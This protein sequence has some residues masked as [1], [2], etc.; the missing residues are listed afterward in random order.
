M[1]VTHTMLSVVEANGLLKMD[2]SAS[3]GPLFKNDGKLEEEQGAVIDIK[4]IDL[5]DSQTLALLP[6]V[7][8][9][10]FFLV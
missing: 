2:S 9:R 8:L 7:R 5:E 10:G 4:S 1:M 6:V 3:H